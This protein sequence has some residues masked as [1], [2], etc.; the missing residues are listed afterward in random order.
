MK[1]ILKTA[2]N[3]LFR[4]LWTLLF[5]CFLTQS[6]AQEISLKGRITGNENSGIPGCI[7]SDSISGTN[8]VSDKDGRYEILLQEG[9]RIIVFRMLG[10]ET[11]MRKINLSADNNELNIKLKEIK[12]ELGAVVVSAAKFEQKLEEVTVSMSVIEAGYIQESHHTSLETAIEQVPGVTVIDGQANIR[13][14]SGFSY[15]AGS[16]VLLLMDDLPLLAGDAGDVKWSFLP[17]ENIEQVEIIKGA[18][19]ALFGSSALNGVINM[20]T[21]FPRDTPLTRI[22]IYSGFYDTPEREETKWWNDTRLVN[23][24]EFSH[25]RKIKQLDLV[26]GGYYLKDDGYRLGETEERIRGTINLRYRFKKEGLTAGIAGMGQRAEGGNYLIWL[27]KDSGALLPM[28]SGAENSTLSNYVTERT[29]IDPYFTYST[30]AFTHR[31]RTRYFLTNNKNNTEQESKALVLYG[32][33]LVQY[34]PDDNIT[35]SLGTSAT[36]IKVTGDLYGDQYSENFA[37]FSQADA[38]FNRLNLSAGFRTENAELSGNKLD[39][40]YL[41]RAGANYHI[42]KATYLRASYGQGFRFPSI[43]EKYVRTRVG[44]IVIYPNDSLITETGWSAE[45]AVRQDFKIGSWKGMADLALFQTEYENMMEFVFG[46]WGNFITDPLFGL[47]FKSK[48][49]GNT[50]ITGI[51]ISTG[52]E[53]NTGKIKHTLQA[54][55]TFID[56]VQKDFLLSRDTLSNS[57][58]KNV[59]KYRYRTLFKFDYKL[60]I[61]KFSF[62]YTGRYYSFMENIDKAF[63]LAIAGVKQ[64]REEN[65]SGEWVFDSRISYEVLKGISFSAM[66]KNILN[67]EVMGRPADIQPP[68]TFTFRISAEF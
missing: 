60:S 49:I 44:D 46:A 24:A 59:L 10:Y 54:G 23:G 3:Y 9:E 18:S 34:R 55:A 43:A 38:K 64:Y 50:R 6:V 63:E 35:I 11:A 15:G 42:H 62:G 45:I 48:N 22:N 19:S 7:I 26:T 30:S 36:R 14:G 2:C 17:L 65:N 16:R 21:G 52:A 28:I 20:R 4:Y 58:Y 41:F 32:E 40:E 56:P 13:G 67:N 31:I 5:T 61:G 25:K 8:T 33:Y 29:L 47:G 51:E 66:A 27:D 1:I 53:G 12:L 37:V 57:S 39:P 68:R